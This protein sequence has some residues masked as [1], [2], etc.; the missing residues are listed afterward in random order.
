ML[1]SYLPCFG[2]GNSAGLS[3]G[4]GIGEEKGCVLCRGLTL[5][6]MLPEVSAILTR[7]GAVILTLHKGQ[8]QDLRP[9]RLTSR[10][11]FNTKLNNASVKILHNCKYDEYL[12]NFF[13]FLQRAFE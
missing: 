7:V 9:G 11:V 2:V 4:S 3:C 12:Y 5:C 10:Y 1:G 13:F 6:Q 8:S